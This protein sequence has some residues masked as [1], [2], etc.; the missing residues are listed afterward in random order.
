MKQTKEQVQAE[1]I[2]AKVNLESYVEGDKGVRREFA[3]AF[4]WFSEKKSYESYSDR[5]QLEPSWSEIFVRVGKLLAA[6]KNLRTEERLSSV[7][8]AF[9][10]MNN[11][12]EKMDDNIRGEIHPNFPPTR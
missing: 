10:H 11:R 12:I 2:E 5:K 7:E 3:K 9:I 1:L 4:D 6:Q 8:D